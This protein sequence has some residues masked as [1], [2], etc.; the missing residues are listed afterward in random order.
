MVKHADNI[1]KTADLPLVPERRYFTIGEVSLLCHLKPHILRYW[2]QE[3]TLLA[4]T[5]R[6]GNRRYYQKQDIELVRK[7]RSLLYEEG[8]TLQGA[9]GQLRP[10][11][12]NKLESEPTKLTSRK[13]HTI[14]SKSQVSIESLKSNHLKSNHLKAKHFKEIITELES[15]AKSLVEP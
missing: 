14:E 12:P 9:K 6:R 11:R 5:K 10:T 7:I 4:P 15:V 3:F 8:Y 13:Q 2:E 1:C